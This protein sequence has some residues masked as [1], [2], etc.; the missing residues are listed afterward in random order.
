[1]IDS[2]PRAESRVGPLLTF[3]DGELLMK[4]TIHVALAGYAAGMQGRRRAEDGRADSKDTLERS[5][6][7]SAAE[8]F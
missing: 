7:D 8:R 1:M 6:L 5:C 2:S 3:Y 4:V